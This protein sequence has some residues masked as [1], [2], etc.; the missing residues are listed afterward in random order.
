MANIRRQIELRGELSAEMALALRTSLIT[1]SGYA[2]Q[3]AKNRDPELA[4]QIAADIA[5]EARHLDY[6]IGGF[7]AENRKA[8][9]AV[10]AQD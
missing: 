9:A 2:Q 7:L 5:A 8:Q 6:T 4:A 1:I 10:A 3:L